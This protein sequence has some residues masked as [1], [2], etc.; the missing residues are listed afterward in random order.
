MNDE[1][2]TPLSTVG[3]VSNVTR[4]RRLI[5]L[6]ALTLALAHIMWPL[7]AIDAVT[8]ALVVIALAPWLAPIFKS[9]E[10]PGGLKLEFRDLQQAAVRADQLGLIAPAPPQAEKSEYSFEVV[11][12]EDP[13]LALAGLRIEIEKRLRVLAGRHGLDAGHR[14][15]G[16]LLRFLEQHRVLNGDERAVLGDLAGL[17]NSAV[18]GAIVDSRAATWAIE[19]GPRLLTALDNLVNERQ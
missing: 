12:P 17:L 8:L 2:P 10:L 19:V 5:T 16:Q 1:A 15:M 9:L 6:G 7:L 4:L 3:N 13:N 14:G 11:A 18:H